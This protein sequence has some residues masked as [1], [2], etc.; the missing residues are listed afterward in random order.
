MFIARG[1]LNLRQTTI[2]GNSGVGGNVGVGINYNTISGGSSEGAGVFVANGQINVTNSTI[3]ENTASGGREGIF[4][5]C[6]LGCTHWERGGDAAGGGLYISRGGVF[7]AGDTVA[8]NQ[9]LVTTSGTAPGTSQ[10][11]GITNSGAGL[12]INTTLV[13]HNSQ[14]SGDPNNGDDVSGKITSAYSLISQTAGATVTDH[15]GNL[16]NV[17]PSLDPNGLQF[18]GGP[19]QTVALQRS[20]PAIDA[21]PVAACLLIHR[22]L[23]TIL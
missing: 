23:A 3:F 16:F 22:S 11:G 17:D 4:V 20:S 21:V 19:T 14:N 6:G 8:S 13:G 15:G 1:A 7:L 10:G 12:F 2:S 5:P 9:A 18:N